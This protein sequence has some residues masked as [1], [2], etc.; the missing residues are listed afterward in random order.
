MRNYLDTL[1][2]F[3]KDGFA[4]M[5][6]LANSLENNDPHLYT[7][8]VHA[9]KSACA[10]IGAFKL[11]EDAKILEAAGIKRDLVFINKHNADFMDS[12]K[13]L[14]ANVGE[15]ISANI[16]KPD[17]KNL[18]S[19][20]LKSRLAALKTALETFDAAGIDQ[21]ST[22]LQDFTQFLGIGNT[23]ADILQDAFIGQYKQAI[24]Q[25]EEVMRGT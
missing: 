5:G 16:E 18:D 1:K 11:S 19:G 13:K 25:I 8:Y 17:A 2:I 21:A 4:K 23:V 14:L 9:L 6:E 10:N 24:M 3:H 12:L 7:T 22:A 20:E 15:I